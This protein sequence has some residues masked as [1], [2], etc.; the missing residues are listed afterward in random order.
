MRKVDSSKHWWDTGVSVLG[1]FK[2][3]QLQPFKPVLFINFLNFS[4]FILGS[5]FLITP[6]RGITPKW[7]DDTQGFMYSRHSNGN[8]C[9]SFRMLDRVRPNWSSE[10]PLSTNL[11]DGGGAC[12]AAPRAWWR[13]CQWCHHPFQSIP[14]VRGSLLSTSVCLTKMKITKIEVFQVKKYSLY[15]STFLRPIN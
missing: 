9:T 3:D 4:T 8:I 12:V 10:V 6:E 7:R 11:P 13:W 14:V 2:L 5:P 15:L 1:A